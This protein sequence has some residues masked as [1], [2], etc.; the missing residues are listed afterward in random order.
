MTAHTI[1][2]TVIFAGAALL[3]TEVLHMDAM[4]SISVGF[5]L[6][7]LR[8]SFSIGKLTSRIEYWMEGLSTWKTDMDNWRKRVETQLIELQQLSREN[9][10]K[11]CFEENEKR[12]SKTCRK[13][14]P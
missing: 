6:V 9:L 5:L 13:P 12:S 3:G 7:M 4:M 2:N 11:S 14:Q 1:T 10:S 8:L